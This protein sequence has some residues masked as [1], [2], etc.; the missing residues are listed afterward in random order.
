[1]AQDDH[2]H[3]AAADSL[4]HLAPVCCA[5]VPEDDSAGAAVR[6]EILLA[7]LPIVRLVCEAPAAD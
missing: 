6:Q 4:A 3:T 7:G 2:Q 5:W 1:M